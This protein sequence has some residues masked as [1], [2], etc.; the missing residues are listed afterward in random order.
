[1]LKKLLVLLSVVTVLGACSSSANSSKE[2]SGESLFKLEDI[3]GKTVDLAD[4]EG[5]N[6]YVKFWASWCPICLAGLEEVN[7]LAAESTDFEV[8]TVVA[9]GYNNEKDKK[10]F[11]KWFKGVENVENLSVLLDEGGK[12]VQDFEVR[13]YPTSAFINKEGELV[14]TQPGQ[15]SNDQIKDMMD[16]LN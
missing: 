16:Q 15:L 11:V 10:G 8:L 9:P 12:L 3:N 7:T 5:K 14:K 6:V 13:G 1:M 2:E 4:Y